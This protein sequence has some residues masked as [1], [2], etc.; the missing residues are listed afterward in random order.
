MAFV[1]K[2]RVG[3]YAYYQV[4][5][6]R[7]I[8]GKVRQKVLLHLGR[9]PTVDEALDAWPR[10][11]QRL[12]RLAEPEF[13]PTHLWHWSP[14]VRLPRNPAQSDRATAPDPDA[15]KQAEELQDK[16]DRLRD[17]RERGVM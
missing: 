3:K 8:E 17:L 4:V 16:L 1:R 13:E 11:I 5:E 10:E 9:H 7:R 2:K 14:G 15:A 12:R 6:N